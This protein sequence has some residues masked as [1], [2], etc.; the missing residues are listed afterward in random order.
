MSKFFAVLL[1]VSL[2]TAPF[3]GSVAA[4]CAPGQ[5]TYVVKTGDN[6][7]RIGLAFGVAWPTIAAAN[8]IVSA[9][10]IY[11]GQTLCIPP[12]VAGAPAP[13][14][15]PATAPTPAPTV[16]PGPI[17]AGYPSFAIVSVVKGQNVTIRASNFPPNMSFDV[18]MGA[19]GTLGLGGSK[20]QTIH[21]GAGGVFTA[22]YSLPAAYSNTAQIAIRLQSATGYYA[23]NWF[24]NATYPSL[25]KP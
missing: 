22:T 20:V 25:L 23:F 6:L 5:T 1:A 3:A 10:L 11:I 4:A 7:Y 2:L 13:T 24:Y 14:A 18:L 17:Y 12:K 15:I 21:S 19:Y 16:V 8:G 9:N